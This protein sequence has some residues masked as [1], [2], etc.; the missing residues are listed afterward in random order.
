MGD[1]HFK[2]A[3]KKTDDCKFSKVSALRRE[4]SGRQEE[5]CVQVSQLRGTAV[6]MCH[7]VHLQ[8]TSASYF[9]APS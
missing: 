5:T 6:L 4:T 9:L 1:L 3:E 2:K 7:Q 8:V